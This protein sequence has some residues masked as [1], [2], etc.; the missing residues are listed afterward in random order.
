[1][2]AA[3]AY[4]LLTAQ[5]AV[6][7]TL[8]LSEYRELSNTNGITIDHDKLAAHMPEHFKNRDDWAELPQFLGQPIERFRGTAGFIA[9]LFAIN[10]VALTL[11]CIASRG[12][13]RR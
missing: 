13:K 9:V 12:P 10:A 3:G 4:V 5:I 11:A 8:M 6:A 2:A 1:M 7:Q